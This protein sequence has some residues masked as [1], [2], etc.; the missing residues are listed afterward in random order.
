MLFNA[1]VLC[2]VQQAFICVV[3]F[4]F[5]FNIYYGQDF[6]FY[7]YYGLFGSNN[8]TDLSCQLN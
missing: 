5:L 6:W 2:T 8:L 4:R 7:R 1:V 3:Y